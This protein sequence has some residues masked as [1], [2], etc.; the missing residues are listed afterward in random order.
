M[1]YTYCE[2]NFERDSVSVSE[3]SHTSN[4]YLGRRTISEEK[5]GYTTQSNTISIDGITSYETLSILDGKLKTAA[6]DRRNE[7]VF[8]EVTA[9]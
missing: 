1:T 8:E 3:Y 6:N 7:V 9:E 4:N 2:L 5:Y